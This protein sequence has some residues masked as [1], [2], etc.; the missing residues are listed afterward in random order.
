MMHEYERDSIDIEIFL[1][2]LHEVARG[3]ECSSPV[4]EVDTV[5]QERMLEQNG[6]A[7]W[8]Q[9]STFA[10]AKHRRVRER[11]AHWQAGFSPCWIIVLAD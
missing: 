11:A 9:H 8:L 2:S 5:S 1:G 3:G 7:E 4:E 10:A 6:R